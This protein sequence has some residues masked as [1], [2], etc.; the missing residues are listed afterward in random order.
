M[1]QRTAA[2]YRNPS[3]QHPPDPGDDSA[4]GEEP[5]EGQGAEALAV[6]EEEVDE[7]GWGGGIM[8]GQSHGV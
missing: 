1:R 2:A 7:G 5:A 4:V 8:R 6:V 3:P